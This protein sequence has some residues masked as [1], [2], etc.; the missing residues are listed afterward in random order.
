MALL[1]L[2]ERKEIIKD[3]CGKQNN[4]FLQISTYRFPRTHD[5][6]PYLTKG[7]LLSD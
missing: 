3:G 4:D 7:I 2:K 6:G 1:E 5:S